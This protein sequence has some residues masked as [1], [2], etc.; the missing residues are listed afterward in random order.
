[1]SLREQ[2]QDIYEEN[3]RLTPAL[4]VETA[5]PADHPLHHRFEW[6]DAIAGEA[7]RL[8]QA[9]RLIRSVKIV[10]VRPDSTHATARAFLSVQDSSGFAYSPTEEVLA[11][12]LLAKMALADMEREWRQFKARWEHMIEF[13]KLVLG[14]LEEAV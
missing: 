12:P 11:D 9:Q 8:D 2:L 14:D 1:M 13:R 5:R 4:V 10:R 6:D 3:G 7:W